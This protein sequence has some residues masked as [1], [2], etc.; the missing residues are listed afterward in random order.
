ESWIRLRE[1]ERF[2]DWEL[3]P[4]SP[5]KYGL[6]GD[7]EV[8]VTASDVPEQPYI[9]GE[10]PVKITVQ[11]QLLPDWALEMHSAAS[12][13]MQ[14]RLDPARS[15]SRL[16]LVP[17]GSARLRIGEFPVVAKGFKD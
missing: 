17:Y 12:P 8:K 13:P 5:W 3:Y 2:H 16:E 6:L 15:I 7:S 11:G 4:A 14:P 9:A 10:A 1:R